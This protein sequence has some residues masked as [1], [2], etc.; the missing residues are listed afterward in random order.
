MLGPALLKLQGD[1]AGIPPAER[2]DE[3]RA[4]LHELSSLSASAE[5][6]APGL[7]QV[8]G[9]VIIGNRDL[10]SITRPAIPD[11]LTRPDPR[12]TTCMRCGQYF[13]VFTQPRA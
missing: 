11:A 13:P 12:G 9:R 4:L 2:N 7:D 5:Q 8:R 10:F 1:L 3:Q 6:I